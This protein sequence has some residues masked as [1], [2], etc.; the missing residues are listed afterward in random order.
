M[1]NG[2]EDVEG[3]VKLFNSLQGRLF[4]LRTKWP[5]LEDVRKLKMYDLTKYGAYL[6]EGDVELTEPDDII[7]AGSTS[8]TLYYTEPKLHCVNVQYGAN[9]TIH[10]VGYAIVDVFEGD[11]CNVTE[12]KGDNAIIIHSFVNRRNKR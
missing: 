11:G 8:M 6:D 3:L 2:S 12:I 4:F 10:A 5:T 9:V 1:F 7:V